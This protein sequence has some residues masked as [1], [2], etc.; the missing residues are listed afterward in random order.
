M[1]GRLATGFVAVL[2]FSRRTN[3][4]I[5]PAKVIDSDTIVVADQLVRLHGIDAP[6]M[7]QSFWWRGQ[8]IAHG[9]MSLAALEALIAGV[10]VRCE[11]VERDRHG[12]LVAKPSRPI[13]STSAAGGLGGLGAG[14]PAV[15][16]GLCRR[17][18]RGAEGQ[19]GGYV[20]TRP[21]STSV[22]SS[23][24]RAMS[25]S[26]PGSIA[27]PGR[28][29]TSCRSSRRSRRRRGAPGAQSQPGYRDRDW[30]PDADLDRRNRP[31]RAG[32][33]AGAP[34]GRD[35]QRR[36]PASIEAVPRP[37]A[38]SSTRSGRSKPR[39]PAPARSRAVSG[40]AAPRF[41]RSLASSRPSWRSDV[42]ACQAR[43]HPPGLPLFARSLPTGCPGRAMSTRRLSRCPALPEPPPAPG[44]RAPCNRLYPAR[45]AA[46][47]PRQG[48]LPA[49]QAT[50]RRLPDGGPP[51]TRWAA[52]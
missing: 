2:T 8:Q 34:A 15:L 41:I 29:R 23:S 21:S 1:L 51:T 45:S 48:A 37:P 14:V 9:T 47:C 39:A 11:V 12:R 19:A 36:P 25:W 17:R 6:E 40:S 38:P 10:K 5:G 50:D 13:G 31:V 18:G 26:S 3:C 49:A 33:D 30:P 28:P 27:S 42:P 20:G 46:R 43:A 44:S 7:D 16:D 24:A 4:L 32:A 52:A 22:S 35:R